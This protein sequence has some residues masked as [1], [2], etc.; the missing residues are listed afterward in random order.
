MPEIARLIGGSDCFELDFLERAAAPESAMKLG[1]RLHLAGLSLSDTV[2]ILDR[3][4]I[5]RRRTT[6]HNWVQ[7]AGLQPLNGASPD[8]VAVDETVIQLDDERFWLY[9]AVDPATNRLLHVKLAPTR[10]QAITEMFLAELRDKHLVDDAV[11]LVDSPLWMQAAL[12][13]RGF[14]YRYETHGNRNGI[15]R[16]FRELK[17]RTN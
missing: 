11:S 2:S 4:G 6:V 13:R 15:E 3:S 12:H 7:K 9:T 5:E 14:D 10:N 8:H 17:R 16:I 1:I